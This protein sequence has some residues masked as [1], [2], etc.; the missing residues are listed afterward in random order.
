MHAECAGCLQQKR[1]IEISR[2]KVCPSCGITIIREE[3][4]VYEKRRK[5]LQDKTLELLGEQRKT[6]QSDR[7]VRP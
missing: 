6:N 5:G 2:V 7:P 4:A 3:T 1:V